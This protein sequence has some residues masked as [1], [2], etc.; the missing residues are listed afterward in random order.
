ME[1]F[2]SIVTVVSALGAGLMAGIFLIFSICVMAALNRLS[3]ATGVA[4]MNAIN[5]TILGPV[6]A[7]LFT[8]TGITS[9]VLVVGSILRWHEPGALLLLAGGVLYLVGSVAVTIAFNAPRNDALASID[10]QDTTAAAQ[11]ATYVS[12]WTAWNHVRTVLTIASA[13]GS[14]PSIRRRRPPDPSMRTGEVIAG[15]H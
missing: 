9:A 10:P 15:A 14:R 1:V 4:A 2:F 7:V 13:H 3:P 8:G 5:A 6:F 12:E 11:W